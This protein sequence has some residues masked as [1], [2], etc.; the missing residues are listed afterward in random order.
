MTEFRRIKHGGNIKGNINIKGK[1]GSQ[2][3]SKNSKTKSNILPKV[4]KISTSIGKITIYNQS[5]VRQGGQRNCRMCTLL[6]PHSLFT[7]ATR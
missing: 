6:H 4:T 3:M 5:L 2:E 1:I 7:V